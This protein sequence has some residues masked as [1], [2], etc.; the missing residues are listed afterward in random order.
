MRAANG[1]SS[2]DTA[3][4]EGPFLVD[5]LRFM[6]AH[7]PDESAYRD[8]AS[9]ASITFRSWEA[10]SNRLAR[11]LAECRVARGDRVAIYLSSSNALRWIVT[12]AAVHKA[13]AVAVPTNT[14]LSEREITA[15]LG[16]AEVVAMVADEVTL[17]RALGVRSS[18]PSLSSLLDASTSA[19]SADGVDGV[20]RWSEILHHD[21]AAFQVPLD[22]SDLADIMYTSGTTGAP[23][24]VAVR[25]RDVAMMPNNAP[26]WT[27]DTWLHGA[28]LFTFAGIAFVYSP[29][30]LGLTG[31]YLPEFD[32]GRWLEIV[33]RDRPSMIFLVPAMAELIVAHPRFLTADLSSPFIVSVGS[34]PLAPATLALLRDRMPQAAVSNSYGLTEAG[35]AYIVMPKDEGERRPGSIGKAMSPME[36]RIVAPESGDEVAADEIGELQTRLPS[37]QREYYRDPDATSAA[38]TADGWLR[39]GD[40][41]YA[42]DDGFIYLVGR[43]KDVIIRGGNNVYATDVE[44]V[45]IEHPAVQ[46]CAVVGVPHDVLGEDVGAWVVTKPAQSLSGPDLL[47]FCADR[48]ADYKRPRV[49]HF[50][51]AL[52][53]N[54]TGKVM[55]HL[56]RKAVAGT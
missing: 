18:L 23:K 39:T 35:P 9:E 41:A 8:L 19:S 1:S 13:G 26:T 33:E 28:P 46:E 24:G 42:D 22:E 48:L 25:H 20:H 53:R 17:T 16:H 7:H 55:K 27:G 43:L 51:D 34:S 44:A 2:P 12:Y 40:L 38:W 10:E 50:V 4:P 30:K 56:L 52:P 29:M 31:S 47:A 3:L 37:K 5:Q 36:T 6:A 45:I 32:A 49:V 21:D 11:W 54:A 15:V 14:R